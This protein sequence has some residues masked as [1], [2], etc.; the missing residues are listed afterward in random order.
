MNRPL[1]IY[2][3][4]PGRSRGAEGSLPESWADWPAGAES[5]VPSLSIRPQGLPGPLT[6]VPGRPLPWGGG[7]AASSP[8]V[9]FGFLTSVL[10]SEPLPYRCL[11]G[12]RAK[13]NEIFECCW[14]CFLRSVS[15]LL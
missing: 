8:P 5:G 4:G 10:R 12:G 14:F 1:G 15:F 9:L 13:G 11:V 7:T 6:S 2:V 3:E